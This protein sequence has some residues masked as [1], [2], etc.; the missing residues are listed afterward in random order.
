MRRR[1][2]A[3][4]SLLNPD[5]HL[6]R[7]PGQ[8]NNPTPGK[9]SGRRSGLAHLFSPASILRRKSPPKTATPDKIIRRPPSDPVSSEFRRVVISWPRTHSQSRHPKEVL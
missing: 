9:N 2:F 8:S 5:F 4:L 6:L 7:T 1:K 3:P